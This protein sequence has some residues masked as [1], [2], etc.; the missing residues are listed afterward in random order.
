M[1][2]PEMFRALLAANA[3]PQKTD[4]TSKTKQLCEKSNRFVY[5]LAHE[6]SLASHR[7]QEHVQKTVPTMVSSNKHLDDLTRDVKGTIFDL[8]YTS[9]VM[10]QLDESMRH[11]TAAREVISEL[12]STISAMSSKEASTTTTRATSRKATTSPQ[13]DSLQQEQQ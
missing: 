10:N 8:E 7:I 3:L 11:S 12:A 9:S 6:P 1:A 13:S 2:T 4:T 5:K